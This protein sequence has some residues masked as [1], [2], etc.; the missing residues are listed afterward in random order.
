MKHRT[1]HFKDLDAVAAWLN[2]K[3]D[4][5]TVIALTSDPRG[6]T[7]VL[8]REKPETQPD[9]DDGEFIVARADKMLEESP[10][11]TITLAELVNSIRGLK[12][13]E[14]FSLPELRA[15]TAATVENNNRYY[16]E[17]H[18]RGIL[19]THKDR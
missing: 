2:R 13:Y 14:G 12:R 6:K 8:Y 16:L 7:T 18:R 17:P 9:L 11:K 5:V 4:T 3:H 1:Q 19:I 10:L 15:Y